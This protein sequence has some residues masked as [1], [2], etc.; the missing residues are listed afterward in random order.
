M[1]NEFFLDSINPNL[2]SH[3]G[4][5]AAMQA[6]ADYSE[7]PFYAISFRAGWESKNMHSLFDYLIQSANND[8]RCGKTLGGWVAKFGETIFGGYPPELH[9]IQ[10]ENEKVGGFVQALLGHQTHVLPQVKEL[11]IASLLR[12][13]RRFLH[14]ISSEPNQKYRN[15]N[16]HP[17]QFAMMKALADAGVSEET[18]NKW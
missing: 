10:M 12:H 16:A 17:F 15:V 11:I 5:K 3:C 13:H 7:L 9:A 2:T 4:K 14:V 1:I 8:N 6:M 18:F